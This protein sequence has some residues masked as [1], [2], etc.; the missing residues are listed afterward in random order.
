HASLARAREG[1]GHPAIVRTVV[2][3]VGAGAA[4]AAFGLRPAA[5]AVVAA[6][7]I[8]TLVGRERGSDDSDLHVE[9]EETR[10]R[11]EALAL[12]DPLTGVLNHRAFQ[13][14]LEVELRRAR[15]ESWSV[16]IVAIDID[17]L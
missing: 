10:K 3:A 4:L 17:G 9:L 2:F 5:A 8:G 16:A 13:D 1:F 15:R 6:L 12:R 14:A 11:L 7:A